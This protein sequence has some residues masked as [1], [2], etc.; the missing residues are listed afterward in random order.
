MG[1]LTTKTNFSVTQKKHKY[2][3]NRIKFSMQAAN[4]R[5]TEFHQINFFW[6]DFMDWPLINNGRYEETN[7]WAPVYWSICNFA[8]DISLVSWHQLLILMKYLQAQTQSEPM[9]QILCKL[10]GIAAVRIVKMMHSWIDKTAGGM[11][12]STQGKSFAQRKVQNTLLEST[13]KYVCWVLRP[14]FWAG[15]AVLST[16]VDV[17]D[18]WAVTASARLVFS[19]QLQ[20][21]APALLTSF[22]LGEDRIWFWWYSAVKWNCVPFYCGEIGVNDC[23]HNQTLLFHLHNLGF[24]LCLSLR[25]SFH[26]HNISCKYCLQQRHSHCLMAL[27]LPTASAY[28]YRYQITE[29]KALSLF[30]YL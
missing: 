11:K 27:F 2:K 18:P 15:T 29:Q 17:D 6:S 25:K 4:H 1:Q 30:V 8:L 5:F 3:T 7:C 12:I 19:T 20:V 23:Y 16:V 24:V 13:P 10:Q 9:C 14:L 28:T 21:Q 26:K 22:L